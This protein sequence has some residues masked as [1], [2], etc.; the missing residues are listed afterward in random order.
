[1]K[2]EHINRWASVFILVHLLCWTL[3]PILV[4]Y[5]LPLDSI[6]GT[7]WGHQL[8]L[9]Y[10]K[11][12]FMNAWLTALAVYL[13]GASG[14]MIYLF[15]QLSVAIC[16]WC[17]WQLAKNMLSPAYALI[18]V[19]ILEGIQYYHFHA[20]DFNDNTLELSLWAL[21]SYFFYFALRTP[22]YRYWIFT[23]VFAALGMMAK[24]YTSALLT[25]MA[26]L[27]LLYPEHRKQLRTFPPYVG[28]LVFIAIMLPH[29]IWLFFHEFITVTYVFQRASSA[30]SWT[31][32][33]F[34]PAQFAWQQG[35]AF[36][37]ALILFLC[38]L[39]GKKPILA[40]KRLTLSSFDRAFIF[41]VGFG[42][43]L[44][45][46]LLSLC[47]GIKLRAG[48]GM[49]LLSF[50]GIGLVAL[51]QPNVTRAKL[52]QFITV[53]F[54]IM[55]LLVGGYC[56]SLTH[57]STSS[58]ANFPGREIAKTI[59]DEWHQTYHTPLKYVAGS[60]WVGGNIGFYSPDHPSVF[61][62]W[63][64]R[65]A[66]WINLEEMRKNGAV[67]VWDITEGETLPDEVKAKFPLVS[68]KILTFSWHR[69]NKL[70]PV[71]IGV[72]VLAPK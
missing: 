44:L 18:A 71:Q 67:F 48:W 24:Y 11:N 1:M 6:E 30:P 35:Q 62:E 63:D 45:T 2:I 43:F 27:L 25:A 65:K 37:P 32:H 68:E 28:M 46:V 5:N 20:I 40:T 36:L 16:F 58:S 56:F 19:M 55:T 38:V 66:P 7:L 8:E 17:V 10:D 14:W 61:I 41:F 60:R 15:S 53:I 22:T 70:A 49:P 59:T 9:G 33:F 12:P 21:T 13:G 31:N 39:V 57:S 64:Q 3:A 26:L 50:W 47:L 72:A 51:V 54:I 34:F 52:Y 4:R 42:P 69:N 23:G 29:I